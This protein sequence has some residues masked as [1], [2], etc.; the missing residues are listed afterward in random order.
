MKPNL[1]GIAHWPCI[2]A[3]LLTTFP[4][5]YLCP[6]SS[7]PL[8]PHFQTISSYLPEMMERIKKELALFP[9]LKFTN[10]SASVPTILSS[11]HDNW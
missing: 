6:L 5:D 4:E 2:L 1:E 3:A 10:L 8:S 9:T 7:K 11:P